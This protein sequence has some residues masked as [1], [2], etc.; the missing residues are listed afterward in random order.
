MV[1]IHLYSAKDDDENYIYSEYFEDSAALSNMLEHWRYAAFVGAEIHQEI[2]GSFFR[3]TIFT[4]PSNFG[5]LQQIPRWRTMD[6]A[7][8]G[9]LPADFACNIQADIDCNPCDLDK[10]P[11]GG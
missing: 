4:I 8:L 11:A 6:C 9:Y 5:G 2:G 7:R 3:H 1:Y 10:L